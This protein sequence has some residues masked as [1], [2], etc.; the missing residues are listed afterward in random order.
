M[1]VH[2]VE[3]RSTIVQV[4]TR[5]GAAAGAALGQRHR[6]AAFSPF[7]GPPKHELEPLLNEMRSG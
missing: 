7:H 5:Q 1:A 6:P 4:D 3:K 2:P